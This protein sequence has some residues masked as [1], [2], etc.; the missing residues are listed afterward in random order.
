M[1]RQGPEKVYRAYRLYEG[2]GRGPILHSNII[3]HSRPVNIGMHVNPKIGNAHY[4]FPGVMTA[5]QAYWPTETE[6]LIVHED[7]AG[8]SLESPSVHRIEHQIKTG[9]KDRRFPDFVL[10]GAIIEVDL[11][12]S[13]E[14]HWS[15]DQELAKHFVHF[16]PARRIALGH[17]GLRWRSA[18]GLFLVEPGQCF[19]FQQFA[20]HKSPAQDLHR[21]VTCV[22]VSSD[23]RPGMTGTA[24]DCVAQFGKQWGA[25]KAAA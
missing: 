11:K 16:K 5:E 21:N 4:D 25:P 8:L 23:M 3:V 17:D 22:Q 9:R 10:A 1:N 7:A 15:L 24:G 20:G 12:Q 14:Q 2:A 19:V 6:F 18:R 13:V